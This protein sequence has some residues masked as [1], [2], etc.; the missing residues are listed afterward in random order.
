MSRAGVIVPR[1][2]FKG[3]SIDR[4]FADLPDGQA[5]SLAWIL[6]PVIQ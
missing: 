5:Y 2:L 3:S 6:D 4:A 1:E